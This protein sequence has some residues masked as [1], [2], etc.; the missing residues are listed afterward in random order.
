[1]LRARRPNG[2]VAKLQRLAQRRPGTW[3]ATFAGLEL[4]KKAGYQNIPSLSRL[5]DVP[6]DSVVKALVQCDCG[7][8]RLPVVLKRHGLDVGN[9]V[10]Q[11][12]IVE[13]NSKCGFYRLPGVSPHGDFATPL[14]QMKIPFDTL[15]DPSTITYISCGA[16]TE[17]RCS[18]V[19]R[20]CPKEVTIRLLNEDGSLDETVTEDKLWAFGALS[21]ALR[22]RE[23]GGTTITISRKYLRGAKAASVSR[24]FNRGP[25]GRAG[26]PVDSSGGGG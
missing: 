16:T 5:F 21:Q 2:A 22:K 17:D 10:Y 25:G 23:V 4:P 15:Y 9:V 7:D 3:F 19:V 1:M 14:D 24:D 18:E 12:K 20:N 11:G 26:R 6:N 13:T 8:A